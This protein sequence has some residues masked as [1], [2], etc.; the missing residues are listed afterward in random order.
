MRRKPILRKQSIEGAARIF[1]EVIIVINA[2]PVRSVNGEVQVIIAFPGES[3][4]WVS[5]M[6]TGKI[7]TQISLSRVETVQVGCALLS[8]IVVHPT[9]TTTFVDGGYDIHYAKLWM[10][11]RKFAVVAYQELTF[12]W[13]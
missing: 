8:S 4:S 12:C 11:A 6:D 1:V 13:C 2:Y 7:D 5:V 9:F 3:N 10:Q